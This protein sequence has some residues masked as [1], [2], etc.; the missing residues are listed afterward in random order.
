[1]KLYRKTALLLLLITLMLIT[2]GCQ[3]KL[4]E[5]EKDIVTLNYKLEEDEKLE[6]FYASET[7]IYAS[8]SKRKP[9][10]TPTAQQVI[11]VVTE[12]IIVYDL[13]SQKVAAQYDPGADG[14]YISHAVPFEK[15]IL[16][17]VYTP[18]GPD[19][20][21]DESIKW[22]IKYISDEGSKIID[23][24]RCS[25][26]DMTPDFTV[27]DGQVYYLFEDFDEKTGYGFGINRADPSGPEIVVEEKERRLIETKFC[28]NGTDYVVHIDGKF[29]V[30]NAKGFYREYDLPKPMSDY[31]ICKNYL[32]CCTE[33]EGE[34]WTARSISLKTG[35]EYTAEIENPLYRIASMGGDELTCISRNFDM[36]I[37]RPG[38]E[39]E[40]VSLENP[41]EIREGRDSVWYYPYDDTKTFAQLE[42]TK[43]CRIAW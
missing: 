20:S 31:G 32:F 3:S 30:G 40:I 36:Y 43:L 4:S 16:C 42:D 2:C 24:G 5:P 25:M 21:L 18:P 13:K 29:L 41:E 27:L 15:G 35:E 22:D 6:P 26:F 1:M 8:V 14:T 37:L 12:K 19:D 28:S 7:K 23:S 33:T 17:S 10:R 11:G 38:K 39:F 34:Q 9:Q